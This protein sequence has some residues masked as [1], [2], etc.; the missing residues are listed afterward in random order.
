MKLLVVAHL[1]LLVLRVRDERDEIRGRQR[2]RHHEPLDLHGASG[3]RHRHVLLPDPVDVVKVAAVDVVVLR[4]HRV[5]QAG[6]GGL[7]AL[8]H[9]AEHVSDLVLPVAAVV[10][11]LR[12]LAHGDA[13][14]EVSGR[15]PGVKR[16][17]PA[18]TACASAR[19]AR[20][21]PAA[22]PPACARCPRAPRRWRRPRPARRE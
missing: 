12:V 17:V 18:R 21:H 22:G 9:V 15:Q 11:E 16:E 19:W 3:R 2:A 1:F 10:R 14:L 7:G 13:G 4:L 6:A 8:F 20:A 5:L